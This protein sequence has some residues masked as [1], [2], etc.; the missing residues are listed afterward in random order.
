LSQVVLQR[1]FF[2]HNATRPKWLLKGDSGAGG[3][4]V[5]CGSWLKER[6]KFLPFRWNFFFYRATTMETPCNGRMRLLMSLF[7]PI[8]KRGTYMVPSLSMILR[9]MSR[10]VVYAM[11][12]VMNLEILITFFFLW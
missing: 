12:T 2:Y 5:L 10:V 11:K 6:K 7:K 3:K 9:D 4:L 8:M 1:Y